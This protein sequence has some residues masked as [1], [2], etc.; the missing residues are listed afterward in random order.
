MTLK[1]IDQ[2]ASANSSVPVVLFG[3]DEHGK[4]KAARFLDKDASLA[5][6]AAEPTQPAGPADHWSRSIRFGRSA[7]RKAAFMPTAVGSCRTFD[8]TC[9]PSYWRR[10]MGD[11]RRGRQRQRRSMPPANPGQGSHRPNEATSR[12]IRG[13]GTASRSGMW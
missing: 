13:T 11:G 9:T 8:E 10:P 5:T 2:Q 7:C 6:K 12:T 1:T 4:P 3:V